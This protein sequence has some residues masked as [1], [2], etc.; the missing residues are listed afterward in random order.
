M[1]KL[2][3]LVSLTT[4]NNDYQIE[5][6]AAAE[7]AA[8]DLDVALEIIYAGSDAIAQS[9]QLLKAI[10]S[11]A[12]VRPDAVVFE[13]VGATALPQVARA[14]ARVGIAWAALN[15]EAEYI[16]ELRHAARAPIFSLSSDHKEIG[17]IQ[18]R[19]FA[20]LLPPAGA[21]LYIQG[22]SE[23]SAA[24]DRTIGMQMTLP[25][26]TPVT[27]L[28]GQWTEESAYKSVISW[29]KLKTANRAPVHVIG[30]QNDAMAMGA[31]KAFREV[32]DFSEREHWLSL[33]YTGCDGLPNTG[34][35]WV[36][37]GTL[38]ATVIVPPNAGQAMHMIVETLE[39]ASK[40][41]EKSFT[42]PES[43]PPITKL[44][45]RSFEKKPR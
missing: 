43:Y 16:S 3:F 39:N 10:Q 41:P 44:G 38:A 5:Q 11:D 37:N 6:A 1:K 36:R 15:R 12:P 26:G 42:V 9:T 22:P 35:V 45:A 21:L 18:G 34:Q 19:Q 20:A 14:A 30:A 4:E 24:R 7:R 17:R 28:R 23:N 13:P 33:P 40:A 29:L 31:R 2:R 27:V 8:R 25:A 32:E